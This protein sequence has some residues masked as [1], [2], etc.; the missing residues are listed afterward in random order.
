[1]SKNKAKLLTAVIVVLYL[2]VTGYE[3]AC[4]ISDP[5]YENRRK[6]KEEVFQD[7]IE[8]S[9]ATILD[10]IEIKTSGVS[11]FCTLTDKGLSTIKLKSITYNSWR[12]SSS[13]EI[14]KEVLND[15]LE[16]D[17]VYVNTVSTPKGL[18]FFGLFKP[19]LHVN[20]VKLLTARN[21]EY[22]CEIDNQYP[23]FAIL[24]REKSVSSIT[25]QGMDAAGKVIVNY[26]K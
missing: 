24:T 22:T 13:T 17:G 23:L 15:F 12:F 10:V 1:M 25:L 14:G 4:L 7:V 19:G 8:K 21:K 16:T 3:V 18:L 2:L 26:Q 5:D 20:E 6:T 11:N 9:D